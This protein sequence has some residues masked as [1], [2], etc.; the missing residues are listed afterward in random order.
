MKLQDFF[1][2]LSSNQHYVLI[3]FISLPILALLIGLVGGT[4]DHLS[5]WKYMYTAI[6]YMVSIPGIFAVG[7]NVYYFLFQRQDIMQTDLLLQVLPIVTMVVTI[8]IMKKNINLEFVP[9]FDKV[10]ALWMILFAT[11]ALMW[12]L[13]RIHIVVFSYLPFQYLIAIF[14][15]IFGFIYFGWKKI[16]K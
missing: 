1:T 3:Y 7:L 2:I 16:A 4:K 10:Y 14:L 6:V 11:M 15:G 13:E 8:F 9:G 12:L 5:P